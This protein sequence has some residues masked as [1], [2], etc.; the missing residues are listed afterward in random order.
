MTIH[1]PSCE[2]FHKNSNKL[3]RIYVFGNKY[4]ASV[5]YL[6]DKKIWEITVVYFHGK[7]FEVDKTRPIVK[8][9]QE[10]DIEEILSQIEKFPARTLRK[11]EKTFN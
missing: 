8:L 11:A 10:S 1:K 6:G 2:V 5:V 3:Q 7:D 9:T 4:G